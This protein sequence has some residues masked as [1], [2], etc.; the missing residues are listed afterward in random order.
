ML[1]WFLLLTTV[2][3]LVSWS[4]AW[5]SRWTG[6]P[7]EIPGSM[8]WPA[9]QALAFPVGS[10]LVLVLLFAVLWWWRGRREDRHPLLPVVGALLAVLGTVSELVPAEQPAA[11]GSDRRHTA[12]IVSW[13][14]KDTLSRQDLETLMGQDPQAIVLPESNPGMVAWYLQQIGASRKYQLFHSQQEPDIAPT[15][16]L[17]SSEL[18][19]Y[20]TVKGP[21]T[22]LG[23]VTVEP[24]NSDFPAPRVIGVHTASPRLRW[25]G[26]WHQELQTLTRDVC[27]R[28]SSRPTV[29]AGD[30]NATTA[31]GSLPG[32]AGSPQCTD[33]LPAAGVGTGTWPVAAPSALRAQIDH[34]LAGPGVSVDS[35]GIQDGLPETSDH[36]AIRATVRY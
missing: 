25:M 16:V 17:V 5:A 28:G 12:R 14:S 23:T 3:A 9:A 29:A 31:H 26:A 18:G 35:A 15:T 34:V 1:T 32:L 10:G 24:E 2:F 33:A 20:H 8:L 30:F 19:A 22:T 11:S 36:E 21:T 4:A 7:L 13:N 27:D 6:H